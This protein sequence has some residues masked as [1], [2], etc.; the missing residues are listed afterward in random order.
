ML[1][2]TYKNLKTMENNMTAVEWLT[3]KLRIEFGFVFS[4]NILEQAKEMEKQ[5]IKDAYRISTI[6]SSVPIGFKKYNSVEQYYNKTFKQDG[7]K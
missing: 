1:F 3:E 5:Q 7:N 4:N 6:E 2:Y